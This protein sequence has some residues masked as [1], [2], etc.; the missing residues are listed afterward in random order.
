MITWQ[1]VRYAWRLLRQQPA[2]TTLVVATMALGIAATTT[3]GSVA[4][5]VLIKPLPWADAPRLVR[6]YETREGSTRRFRPMMTNAS[7]LAW[8]GQASTLDAI[9]AWSME[10]VAMAGYAGMPRLTIA[11]V[12]PTLFP[13]LQASPILGRTFG[14]GDDRAGAATVI[15]S[16]AMWQ[17][18]FGGRADIVGQT[19]R[20][21]ATTYTIVGVMPAS[22]AFPDRETAAWIP[23]HVDPVTA[24]GRN[25]FL[26][27]MF[28]AIGRLRPGVTPAQAAAEGTARG[29]SVGDVGPVAIAV[30]GS[31]G[32]A[33]VTAVP[34]L[35]ALTGD[36]KPA[37]LVLLAAVALLLATATANVASLQLA[38]AASRRRE[39]AIR[40]AL[41]AARVR[42]VRQMLLEN[43][44]LGLL[45]GAGGLLL[46]ALMHRAL[47]SILPS[48][49]PRMTDVAL[50]WPIQ[51]FTVTVAIAAGLGCGLLPAIQ[52]NRH[53]LAP[54]LNEDARAPIGG[55][56]RTHTARARALIMAGQIAI[57]CVLLVG[58][59]LLSRSFI[60]LMHADVGYDPQN[61][62][63]ARLI[64]PDGD[65]KPERRRQV[66]DDVVS[67]LQA[68]PGVA[69]AAYATGMPFAT[70]G[71]VSSFPL[72]LRDGST[73]TIQTGARLIS[74]GYFAALGQRVIEGR[75][76]TPQDGA[77]NQVV[78][79]NREFSRRYLEGRAMGWTLPGTS[80]R[81]AAG[82][83]SADRP[84]V[85]IVEDT[86]RQSVTDTPEPEI[87]FPARQQPIL[88]DAIAIV[89]RTSD[90]PLLF[91]P[92]LRS[93]TTAAAPSAPL[94]SVMTMD[95]RVA[96]TLT[97]PRLY[98]V[99]LGTFAAFALAIAGVGLFGVLSYTVAL[100]TREIG[101][102]AA[103]GAQVGDIVRLVVR[104]AVAIAATGL[105]V[106]L[107]AAFWLASA[108]GTFLYGVTP[109]DWLSFAAV[110][111]LL[112]AVAVVAS[113]VPARRAAGVDPVEVLRG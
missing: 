45:G 67:R 16:Q 35:D 53:G 75:E 58:A 65:Y 101:V 31:N 2:Y 17:R 4:Y 54:A 93:I 89:V 112:L 19:V 7:Y 36:V 111:A 56:V 34:M 40:S 46:A 102:R 37:I 21:D 71:S 6:L 52:L 107:L 74:P 8:R 3:V 66:I 42:L 99:L 55:G 91:V 22:F 96:L 98:A 62:L 84:I 88:S 64:L 51:A 5:G 103:L 28:Q 61:L 109:H 73:R 57:A 83:P 20:F 104:Q 23:F 32:P 76:F 26:L 47:P 50:G 63:T 68:T 87:F 24:P 1:D 69:R 59:V 106:G 82:R 49:F 77:D 13:M 94:E 33:I 43:L 100:R 29:R 86:A 15:L 12:T 25:G 80:S 72:R 81:S 38:R 41:G 27:S 9:G 11:A 10:R 97:R 78:I 79:V 60:G 30:F 85:G 48:D 90:S 39:L 14:D 44:L 108:L 18:A 105:T 70:G 110:A 92:S 113:I 95:D